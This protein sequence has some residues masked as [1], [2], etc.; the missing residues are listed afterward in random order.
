MKRAMNR[1]PPATRSLAACA[2]ALAALSLPA[3]R[4]AHAEAGATLRLEVGELRNTRGTL[5]CRLFAQPADFPEGEGAVTVRASI[6]GKQASCAFTN[7][8]PGV[9]AVAVVHDENGNGR[10]DRSLLGVPSEGYGVTNNRTYALS[11][12]RWDESKFTLAASDQTVLRVN[13][14]Y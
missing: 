6:A 2:I 5:N 7:L 13:L 10:L 3:H 11:S 4:P 12:P 1:T 14:R 8:T 9:Y